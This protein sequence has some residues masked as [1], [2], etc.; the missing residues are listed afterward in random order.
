MIGSLS[1]GL[2]LAG[3]CGEPVLI[4]RWHGQVHRKPVKRALAAQP[5]SL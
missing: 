1:P 2:V 5:A 3:S 4:Q